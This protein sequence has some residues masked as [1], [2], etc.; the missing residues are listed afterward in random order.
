[1]ALPSLSST[2]H[3]IPPAP[4][5]RETFPRPASP[6]SSPHPAPPRKSTLPSP[7]R[8]PG[9][10]PPGAPAPSP[11]RKTCTTAGPAPAAT[12]P[13]GSSTR[14]TTTRPSGN[15]RSSS[16]T[17]SKI[18]SRTWR[19]CAI[20]TTYCIA[21]STGTVAHTRRGLRRTWRSTS[22]GSM[23]PV[24]VQLISLMCVIIASARW[25]G[26]SVVG[27]RGRRDV[28]V[29]KGVWGEGWGCTICIVDGSRGDGLR[30]RP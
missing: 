9:P 5:P 17:T 22:F 30:R 8:P 13:A 16:G 28:M 29:G 10:R 23:G 27:E 3:P 4:P 24:P 18:T 26:R 15:S 25:R 19:T 11:P 21:S 12:A 14:S 7:R 2:T 1:M 20:G 6:A